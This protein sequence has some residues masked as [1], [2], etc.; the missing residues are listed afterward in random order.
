[1]KSGCRVIAVLF[2]DRDW[3]CYINEDDIPAAYKHAAAEFAIAPPSATIVFP[4]APPGWHIDLKQLCSGA[5]LTR[6]LVRCGVSKTCL[7]ADGAAGI[8]YC[9]G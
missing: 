4:E 8:E 1:M 3:R 5:R 6:S 2:R 9:V 7:L